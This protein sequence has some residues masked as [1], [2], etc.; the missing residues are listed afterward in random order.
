MAIMQT[1]A[2]PQP[3]FPTDAQGLHTFLA[4]A[5]V[6][7]WHAN[8]RTLHIILTPLGELTVIRMGPLY[9]PS[10]LLQALCPGSLMLQLVCTE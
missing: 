5:R 10:Q 1:A 9:C 3:E 6:V 8:R 4:H 7:H 2:G